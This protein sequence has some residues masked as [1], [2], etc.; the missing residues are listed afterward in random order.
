MGN[1]MIRESLLE[2]EKISKLSDFDFRLWVILIL[3][4][5]DYGV[6]DAR[7]EMIKGRGYPLRPRISVRDIQDGLERL[8]AGRCVTRYTAG[9][10]PYV[11]FPNWGA[12]QR[13]RDSRHRYPTMEE[14]DD[15][16]QV[17]AS[18][19]E[20][21]RVAADCGNSRPEPEPEVEPE[22]EYEGRGR[23]RARE[24]AFRPPTVGEAEQYAR[25]MGYAGFNAERFVAYYESNGWRV[26]RNPMKDWRATVRNW[27]SRD[28]E[29]QEKTVKT[30][31]AQNYEQREYR[32]E[33]YGD[34]FF[35]DLDKYGEG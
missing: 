28:G 3:L 18:R 9:G 4:S 19:G 22:L 30:N 16:R 29:R 26:G 2:S 7:P 1:R 10:R 32:D 21:R 25:E 20:L 14:A 27:A 13:L 11:Q 33:D 24:N 23:A 31:Q 15:P 34:D 6:A 12:H 5:D 8:A 17:A 35:I